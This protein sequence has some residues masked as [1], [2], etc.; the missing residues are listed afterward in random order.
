MVTE[1]EW[2]GKNEQR[3]GNNIRYFTI[4]KKAET[5]PVVVGKRETAKISIT[6]CSSHVQESFVDNITGCNRVFSVADILLFT[7]HRS[8][9]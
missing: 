7:E 6:T 3:P 5:K 8:T 1:S 9:R 2:S 4:D